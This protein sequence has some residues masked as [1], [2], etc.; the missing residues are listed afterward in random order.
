MNVR[1]QLTMLA[2][3]DKLIDCK[4]RQYERLRRYDILAFDGERGRRLG[5]EIDADVDRLSDANSDIMKLI[6]ST[7]ALTPEELDVL[8]KHYLEGKSY[9][10]IA[11]EIFSTSTSVYRICKRAVEKVENQHQNT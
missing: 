4:V 9:A 5:A 7:E 11:N 6:D 3:L 2:K 8:Y 10:T 1:E